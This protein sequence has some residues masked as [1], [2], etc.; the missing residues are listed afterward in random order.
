MKTKMVCLEDGIT[1]CGF[2]K[3]AAY[4]AQLE[5]DT[6]SC[7]ITTTK[8]WRSVRGAIAGTIGD[9]PHIGDEQIDEIAH[10]LSDAA[11]DGD[12][13]AAQPAGHRAA[14]RRDRFLTRGLASAFRVEVPDVAELEL[15]GRRRESSSPGPNPPQRRTSK[16]RSRARP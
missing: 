1:S 2:R 4:V 13:D 8:R 16:A 9:K 7:Y 6:E 10:G 5:E 15:I 11:R 3:M 12:C 14:G